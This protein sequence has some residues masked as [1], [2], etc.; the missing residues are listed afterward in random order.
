MGFAGLGEYFLNG[1]KKV[2]VR[3]RQ[4]PSA[5]PIS[6]LSQEVERM[7][8][9]LIGKGGDKVPSVGGFA[10]AGL[11]RLELAKDRIRLLPPEQQ[12]DVAKIVLAAWKG[13]Q[14]QTLALVR[15]GGFLNAKRGLDLA[16]RMKA[17]R[18]RNREN[19]E[20]LHPSDARDFPMM[21]AL[22]EEAARSGKRLSERDAAQRVLFPNSPDMTE[23]AAGAK[24]RREIDSMRKRYRR[25]KM[26]LGR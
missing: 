12:E 23:N 17:I 9:P 14:S 15:D 5:D 10:K 4:R 8:E 24:K 16:I 11:S 26:N 22:I 7:L 25:W 20:R 18:A 21:R 13:G 19:A 1:T 2:Y 6:A 3:H